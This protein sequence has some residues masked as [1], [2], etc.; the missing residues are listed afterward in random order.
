MIVVADAGPLIA[1]SRTGYFDLLRSLYG[2]LY[3]PQAVWDEVVWAG[4]DRP[5]VEEVSA[6]TWIHVVAVK[7]VVAVQ[8]L[9]E[10]LDLGESEAIV[11]A[12]ELQADLLLIDEMRGRRVTEARNIN[13]TGTLGTLIMAKKQGKLAV[14]NP[15]LDDLQA[16]GF[17][18]SKKLFETVCVLAG[19]TKE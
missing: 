18:M 6:A 5:G 17:R 8:L 15:V 2:E 9:Q 10:Q 1:L 13:H 19:E 11:L 12:I 7:N 4:N 16:A 3:L 14:V